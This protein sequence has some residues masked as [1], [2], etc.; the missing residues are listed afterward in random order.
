MVTVKSLIEPHGALI[1]NPKILKIFILVPP[2]IFLKKEWGSIR[3]FTLVAPLVFKIF[4]Y[5]TL[6]VTC[7]PPLCCYIVSCSRSLN[8]YPEAL[9]NSAA[10]LLL[11]AF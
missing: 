2:D 8:I 7:S 10:P 11:N 4:L 3:D 9:R 1:F 5:S 6:L